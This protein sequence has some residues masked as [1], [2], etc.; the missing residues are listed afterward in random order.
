MQSSV[1]DSGGLSFKGVGMV[2]APWSRSVL[3]V[4]VMAAT[5]CSGVAVVR[6]DVLTGDKGLSQRGS[7]QNL[8]ES[9]P[10]VKM[11]SVG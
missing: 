1:F 2:I 3:K 4:I 10:T 5:L 9:S 8:Q 6:Y 7:G 11:V